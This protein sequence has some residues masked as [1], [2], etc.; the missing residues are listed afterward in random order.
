M[1]MDPGL[2][3][4][5]AILS[6]GIKFE[7]Y[8]SDDGFNN[9]LKQDPLPFMDQNVGMAPSA[10]LN[11][12][13]A[14][15][16]A[17]IPSI[18]GESPEDSVIFSDIALKY[19]K[20]MLLEEDLDNE[21]I[22]HHESSLALQAAEKPFYDIL[23]EKYPPSPDQHPLE[24]ASGADS[25]DGGNSNS[26]SSTCNSGNNG[27]A[28]SF[29]DVGEYQSFRKVLSVYPEHSSQS[30]FSSPNSFITVIDGLEESPMNLVQVPDILSESLPVVQF[31]RGVEEASKLLPSKKF[32]VVDVNNNDNGSR[33]LPKKEVVDFEL[34]VKKEEERNDMVNGSRG[35]KHL[36]RQESDL[37]L[38]EGRSH[39]QTAVYFE[40][41]L[42]SEMF[43]RVLLCSE[44]KGG[45]T[46]SKM[47]ESLQNGA[48]KNTQNSQSKGPNG[49]AKTRGKK[50]GKKE[51]VDLRT[52]LIQCAQAVA[53]DDRRT[54]YELL[55]QIRQHS[56]PYGDGSQRLAHC[57]A[58]GLEARLAGNGSQMSMALSKKKTTAADILRAYHLYLSACPFKKISHFFANQSILDAVENATRLH[59]VDFGISFGFQW[60][61]LLQRLAG[62]T[63]G[64]PMVRITGID[65]PQP[66]FR[67]TERVE[68][69][70]RRLAEYARSFDIPFE[71]IPIAK[72][73]ETI[74][75]EDIKIE[76]D[77]VL[78][79]NCLYS[80]KKLADETVVIDSPRNIVL[81]TIRKMNPD[82]AIHGI[83]NGA[84]GAPFF[85]TRFR[86]ALFH[87]SACF[88]ML[89]TNVPREH[90]ERLLIERDLFGRE[91]MNIIACE[92][93]ERDERP[94]TYKQWQVR[95]MRAG[96]TQLPLNQDIMK[97]ARDK[98]KSCY[99]KDFV[100][101]E[102]SQW[103]LQGWKGRIIYALSTWRPDHRSIRLAL[104]VEQGLS[105]ITTKRQHNLASGSFKAQGIVLQ[106]T[107]S[108]LGVYELSIN[109]PSQHAQRPKLTFVLQV[110]YTIRIYILQHAVSPTIKCLQDDL[111]SMSIH[112][113]A[114]IGRIHVRQ[115]NVSI[116]LGH[117]PFQK[118]QIW[119][120]GE[121]LTPKLGN[122]I[123]MIE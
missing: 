25:P 118:I 5:S 43:D 99:H 13:P 114:A 30:S 88:D 57:F 93:A 36:H 66:G 16:S 2:Q 90:P 18:D 113:L 34:E 27:D 20:Q 31:R 67:P 87:W 76:N 75:V 106:P 48:S 60:P 3:E 83:V 68:E 109:H 53:A 101:D 14:P 92:G 12:K 78:V 79:V 117:G 80:F 62:R 10:V 74:Q 98:V 70:G 100:I 44:G 33:F 72:K 46:L 94:E 82:L 86:E 19:I 84:Y 22:A 42:R 122:R 108:F 91:V 28:S 89:E 24:S 11:S 15:S 104:R 119:K 49:T 123:K 8:I 4:L 17:V 50:Q 121:E 112:Y 105:A 26:S 107:R 102:D 120:Q 77:E 9:M 71:Y 6:S 1:V 95:N 111:Y 116:S 41:T 115:G 29:C 58:N 56:S 73:W 96:F 61:C 81:N 37:D 69:T 35:R 21:N 85:I 40:E 39:K 45:L 52:I 32:L 54:A 55:K 51:V 63:G 103:M 59:I 7:D 47:Q 65:F 38:E 97:K 110:L 64:P 23:G